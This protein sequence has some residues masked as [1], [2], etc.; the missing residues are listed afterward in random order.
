MILER[1]NGRL[2]WIKDS[3]AI[4][5][6]P[7]FESWAIGKIE[8]IG[9]KIRGLSSVGG[10]NYFSPNQVKEYEWHYYG[11]GW[12]PVPIGDI[13]IKCVVGEYV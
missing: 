9:T 4:W 2:A 11:N 12:T 5:F 8:N 13:D 6:V 3:H 7:E 1:I 10:S